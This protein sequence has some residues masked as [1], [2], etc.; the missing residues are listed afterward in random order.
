MQRCF[1]RRMRLKWVL[2]LLSVCFVGLY[3]TYKKLVES[4]QGSRKWGHSVD[5][6]PF[7]RQ[8]DLNQI[9]PLRQRLKMDPKK[10]RLEN[11]LQPVAAAPLIRNLEAD[12]DYITSEEKYLR[13][14]MLLNKLSPANWKKTLDAGDMMSVVKS[15]LMDMDLVSKMSCQEIDA[16]KLG[17]AHRSGF[18]GKKAVDYVMLAYPIELAVKSIGNDHPLK[19]A[20]MKQDYNA[21]R[22]TNM[23]NYKLMRELILLLAMDNAAIIEMKGFCLRGE[24][25]DP[26]LNMKGVV[27]VTEGSRQV[28]E[29]FYNHCWPCRLQVSYINFSF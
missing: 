18:Y 10:D 26:R 2:F 25:I 16:L 4:K 7:Q 13:F 15:E 29:A 27:I 24:T 9:N 21:D 11:G 22:C 5:K 19:I 14:K 28:P 3:F 8:N 17:S 20:C 6:L 12:S 23:A 1:P